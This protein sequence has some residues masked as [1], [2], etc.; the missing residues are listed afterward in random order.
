M[1]RALESLFYPEAPESLGRRLLLAPLDVAEGAFR[2]AV[3]LRSL[4]YARGWARPTRIDGLRVVSVGNLTVGGSG[5]TPVVRALA[6]RLQAAGESV[7]ILSRGYGRRAPDARQVEGPPWPPVEA[8]GDEPLMLARSLPG[9]RVWV[10][11]DRVALAMQARARGASVALLDD[12]FQTRRL[13]RDLDVV[14]VDEAVGLGNGHLLP[15]GP[16]REPGSALRRAQLLWLR[17]AER[18]AEV[19]WP[20]GVPRVRA[21]HAPRDV[22]DPSGRVT[23]A[24]ELRGRRVVAFCG[25]ARPTSFRRTVEAL[26]PEVVRFDAFPDHHRY[27]PAELRAL[28]QS[29]TGGAMLL[30]TEKDAVRLPEGFPASVVRLGVAV[31]EGDEQLRHELARPPSGGGK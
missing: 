12:G 9:V 16:L 3:A 1:S 8:V 29:A 17:V 22:V 14:V 26:G 23:P 27:T 5:K 13:G 6:E 24:G 18:P 20:P 28:E 2:G 11:A 10:G 19:D 31:L 15:R 30:T 21:R 25:L 4:A 7:A